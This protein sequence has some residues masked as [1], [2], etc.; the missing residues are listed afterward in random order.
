MAKIISGWVLMASDFCGDET[1]CLEKGIWLHYDEAL[2]ALIKINTPIILRQL[3][4]EPDAYLDDNDNPMTDPASI[5]EHY[6]VGD[7]ARD[8]LFWLCNYN[9]PF[10][11]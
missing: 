10:Y 6:Y 5:C 11:E 8:D 9:I 2:K 7:D 1:V 4:Y 3:E